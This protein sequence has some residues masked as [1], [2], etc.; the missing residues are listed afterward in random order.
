V[1]KSKLMYDPLRLLRQL[2]DWR[3]IKLW[4][5][6]LRHDKRPTSVLTAIAN[7][8]S[9]EGIELIDST[10]YIPQLLAD[11]GVLTKR[12]PTR[13]QQNDITFGWPIVKQ[14]NALDIG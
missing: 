7:T 5:G 10:R 4:Y 9:D 8:F 2:P 13:E 11:E 1:N 14:L 12:Q 3:T 6:T